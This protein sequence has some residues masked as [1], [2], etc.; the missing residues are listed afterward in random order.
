MGG[1]L[2][3]L[4]IIN[5]AI[6]KL[7]LCLAASR[8]IVK[9]K[10]NINC[11]FGGQY[12]RHGYEGLYLIHWNSG[13]WMGGGRYL[14]FLLFYLTGNR[15]R[16]HQLTW[17]FLFVHK[18]FYMKCQLRTLGSLNGLNQMYRRMSSII[19]CVLLALKFSWTL[20]LF[21]RVQ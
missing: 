1:S 21:P 15:K 14:E 8:W 11:R 9:N 3:F 12:S 18:G 19:H 6:K 13:H 5:L 16:S 7:R 10:I 2:F 4:K 17:K 20:Q